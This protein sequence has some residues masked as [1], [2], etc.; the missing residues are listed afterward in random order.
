MRSDIL[1]GQKTGDIAKDTYLELFMHDD[2]KVGVKWQNNG[3]GDVYQ[4]FKIKDI[5]LYDELLATI[6]TELAESGFKEY[7]DVVQF[8][9]DG[10]QCEDYHEKF[11]DYD[12]SVEMRT[13]EEIGEYM[14]EAFD[15]VWLVR[16]QVLFEQMLCGQ[17]TIDVNI[18]KGCM[19][20]IDK[21]CEKYNIDF[22]EPVSDWHYGYWSGILAALRWVMGDEKDFLDK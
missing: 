2:G 14:D 4:D 17:T 9:F 10:M 7:D 13:E 12:I 18:L 11:I 21:V 16:K 8:V 6:K 19:E 20:S 15:R 1:Y 3:I 22:K 5:K